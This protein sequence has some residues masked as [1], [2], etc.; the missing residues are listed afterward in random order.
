[1]PR[2]LASFRLD[3]DPIH[4]LLVGDR[5]GEQAGGR[6]PETETLAPDSLQAA[7]ALRR[8]LWN[9]RSEERSAKLSLSFSCMRDGGELRT[10]EPHCAIN[11][12]SLSP[13]F[14]LTSLLPPSSTA[15]QS[16]RPVLCA[17]CDILSYTHTTAF[18]E[19]RNFDRRTLRKWD[20]SIRSKESIH[21]FKTSYIDH[22]TRLPDPC[23]LRNR[24][25]ENSNVIYYLKRFTRLKIR[26]TFIF[27]DFSKVNNDRHGVYVLRHVRCIP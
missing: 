14:S 21:V 23:T 1:M 17:A 3:T 9:F 12:L 18:Y 24:I 26:D 8:S 4:V 19:I 5:A 16:N 11:F 22:D 15:T 6:Q 2:E 20:C 25:D 7:A 13:S 10:R 27:E